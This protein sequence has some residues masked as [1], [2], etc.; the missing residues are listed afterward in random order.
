M[1]HALVLWNTAGSDYFICMSLR[2][3]IH[4]ADFQSSQIQSRGNRAPGH[5]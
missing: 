2:D 3:S 4:F 5:T 1:F